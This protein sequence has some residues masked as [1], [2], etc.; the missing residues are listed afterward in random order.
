MDSDPTPG[1][2]EEVRDLADELQTFSDDVAE[3]LGRIRGLASR[4]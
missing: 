3:A 1:D 4:A 2:P